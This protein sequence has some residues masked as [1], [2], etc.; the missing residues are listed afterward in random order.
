M[1][2]P[3]L[4]V[5]A[6][7]AAKR[8]V[9]LNRMRLR[10]RTRGSGHGS[11]RLTPIAG[12]SDPICRVDS[13]R[14]S[15]LIDTLEAC[16]FM[17]CAHLRP[18]FGAISQPLTREHSPSPS[19]VR[20]V[21][22]CVRPHVRPQSLMAVSTCGT[23]GSSPSRGRRRAQAHGRWRAPACARAYR[24]PHRPH[25]PHIADVPRLP[26][27]STPAHAPAQTAHAVARAVFF[28]LF[29]LKLIEVEGY[30][31]RPPASRLRPGAAVALST[32]TQRTRLIPRRRGAGE[33]IEWGPTIPVEHTA[34]A[35]R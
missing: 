31:E 5:A 14:A 6:M 19:H 35:S 4:P 23:C 34:E 28:S 18:S 32:S 12:N 13:W 16:A 22:S 15:Y 21:R 30:W 27:I 8:S 10:Q 33:S 1:F 25:V 9:R 17:H 3:H 29:V 11:S 20:D 7:T 26:G 24:R 2:A